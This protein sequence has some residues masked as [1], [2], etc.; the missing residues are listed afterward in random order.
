MLTI[1]DQC[2]KVV[3]DPDS[4][5]LNFKYIFLFLPYHIYVCVCVAM[6]CVETIGLPDIAHIE[7]RTK[8][9]YELIFIVVNVSFHDVHTR[10]HQSFK[11]FHV[12]NCNYNWKNVVLALLL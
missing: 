6:E 4:I 5:F 3:T 8:D 9:S 10:T 12:E 2:V 11:S 7:T 1:G